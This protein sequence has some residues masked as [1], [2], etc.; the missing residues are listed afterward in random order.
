VG[1]E[2][3]T[4]SR[5]F[6]QAVFGRVSSQMTPFFDGICVHIFHFFGDNASRAMREV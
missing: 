2:K 1:K 4:I 6:P 5:L 3:N